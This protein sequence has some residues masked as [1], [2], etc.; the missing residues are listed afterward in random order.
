MNI[1]S[2]LFIV[3]DQAFQKFI[4]QP[5][6]PVIID[7]WA[8]WCGPCHAIA[9][10]FERLSDQ[11]QGKL[12]FARMNIDEESNAAMSLGIQA[13]PTLIVFHKGD[14]AQR[15]IGPNPAR[16]RDEIDRTLAKIAGSAT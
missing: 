2:N 16:L 6:Q 11:Y 7:F 10:V 5:D 4:H 13:I 1:H 3:T 14:V 8:P 12:R 9:P 15:I